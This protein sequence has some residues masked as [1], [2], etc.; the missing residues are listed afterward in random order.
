MSG[1]DWVTELFACCTRHQ[2]AVSEEWTDVP[3]PRHISE[4]RPKPPWLRG[5]PT[6]PAS[7]EEGFDSA[8]LSTR[9]SHVASKLGGQPLKLGNREPPPELLVDPLDVAQ[10]PRSARSRA[11]PADKAMER[12][13][14]RL[15]VSEFVRDCSSPNGRRCAALPLPPCES[16]DDAPCFRR[17]ACY[18]LCDSASRLVLRG[19]AAHANDQDV[20][21]WE[22]MGSWPLD[23]LL[24][25]YRAEESAL[26]HSRMRSLA[27][28]VTAAEFGTAAV[29]EFG[30]SGSC[31]FNVPVLIIE[32]SVEERDRLTAALRILKQYKAE[33]SRQ[34]TPRQ[35][36]PRHSVVRSC[37][38]PPGPNR[39]P[40]LA[41]RRPGLAPD[42]CPLP[43]G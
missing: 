32:Q 8:G 1:K 39:P 22:L 10:L 35:H 34:H 9:T 41:A 23:S 7:S 4:D 16:N 5:L 15:V 2:A 36:T 30:P 27:D 19:R 11:D 42:D 24:G 40:F 31:T 38:P 21:E 18:Q 6:A 29:L 13:R 25:A 43:N 26:V 12:Q 37:T 33:V 3:V 17:V 14:L 20:S 28:V